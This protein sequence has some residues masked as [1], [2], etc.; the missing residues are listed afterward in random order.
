MNTVQTF[1]MP[2]FLLAMR[3]LDG[4]L[5]LA[6]SDIRQNEQLVGCA[7][8]CIAA[9]TRLEHTLQT[10]LCLFARMQ[11]ED[12]EHLLKIHG[13]DICQE[14]LDVSSGSLVMLYDRM[15][16]HEQHFE[17]F[18]ARRYPGKPLPPPE[19]E[20]PFYTPEIV[21]RYQVLLQSKPLEADWPWVSRKHLRLCMYMLEEL[22]QALNAFIEGKLPAEAGT[23]PQAKKRELPAELSTPKAL[24]VLEKLRQGGL[25]DEEYRPASLFSIREKG[26]LAKV[27]SNEVCGKN[28]WKPFESYWK[29]ENLCTLCNQGLSQENSRDVIAAIYKKL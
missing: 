28:K 27:I 21:S 4:N 26:I 18:F 25:L 19:E 22:R 7:N 14:C 23:E 10:L 5:R 6:E 2:D 12:L 20:G 1:S 3:E 17:Q 13:K 16:D 24:K 15:K 29:M 8:L 9:I 11:R